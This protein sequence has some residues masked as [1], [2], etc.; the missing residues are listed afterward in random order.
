M[1]PI[2]LINYFGIASA[3]AQVTSTIN[4]PSDFNANVLSQAQALLAT[5]SI[6]GFVQ[7]VVGVLLA[8]VVLE[9]LIGALTK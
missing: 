7:L 2:F 9:V 4:F 8:V 5:N 1:T 3:N 6:G